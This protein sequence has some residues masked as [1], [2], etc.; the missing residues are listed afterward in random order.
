MG[1]FVEAVQ[2]P[3]LLLGNGEVTVVQHK[4][5][6][7]LTQGSHST[8]GVDAITFTA[9]VGENNIEVRE[10][11]CAYLTYL[12]TEMDKD[13]NAVR[14]EEII[15]SKEGSKIPLLV[16]PTDE[17]MSIARQTVALCR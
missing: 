13:K 7:G 1:C 12:G 16:I 4:G 6:L 3:L 9:G 5:V 2:K 10:K 15:I 8:G 11:I 17:E 14:G